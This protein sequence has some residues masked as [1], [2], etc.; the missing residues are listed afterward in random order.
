MVIE[1]ILSMQCPPPG[2][3]GARWKWS[4]IC[5]STP[6]YRYPLSQ[7]GQ[8]Y[9]DLTNCQPWHCQMS[10]WGGTIC[11]SPYDAPYSDLE[12]INWSMLLAQKSSQSLHC[13]QWPLSLLA[14]ITMYYSSYC[15]CTRVHGNLIKAVFLTLAIGS[16]FLVSHWL[17][18][19]ENPYW[20]WY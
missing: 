7:V 9:R 14:G 20:R 1:C 2:T 10:L 6:Y 17:Q 3:I 13:A 12:S 4:Q 19:T 8:W 16:D 5:L 11:Q 15:M 18:I